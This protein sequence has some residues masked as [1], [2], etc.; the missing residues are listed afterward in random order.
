MS[1]WITIVA[2]LVVGV[3]LGFAW[4]HERGSRP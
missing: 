2:A 1:L 3:G 4:G